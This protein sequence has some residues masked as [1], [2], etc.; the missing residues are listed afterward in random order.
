LEYGANEL[1]GP[2][3]RGFPPSNQTGTAFAQLMTISLNSIHAALPATRVAVFNLPD[4]TSIP[5]FTTFPPFTVSLTTGAPLP[6]VGANGP[7][8]V[9]DL[10]LLPAAG[11]LATGTGIPPGGFNFVNPAAPSNGQPLPEGLILRAAEVTL[12]RTEIS[13][14]N[15]V[16][17]SVA[18]RPF[19]TKVDLAGLLAEISTHGIS[20][21]GNLYTSAFITGGLFG[22]DG[23]H[24]NDLGYALMANQLIDAVNVRFGCGIPLVNPSQYA[25][26]NASRARPGVDLRY[27]AAVNGL[28]HE[29][30]MLYG[31]SH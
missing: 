31:R 25:S 2:T 13:K 23:I 3:T 20:V 10:V 16:V 6:L 28:Q 4:V 8:Q 15:A 12:A 7:L 22:L 18:Q 17:D 9:G 30:D 26:P 14:M 24:P 19:V 21:G 5:Y 1:L 29:L 11:T 27:P